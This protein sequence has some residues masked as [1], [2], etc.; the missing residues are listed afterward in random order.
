MSQETDQRRR[1][2]RDYVI[3]QRN[4]LS[5]AQ[6]RSAAH[7]MTLLL[8]STPEFHHAVHIA[9]YWPVKGEMDVLPLIEQARRYNKHVYLPVMVGSTLKFAPYQPDMPMRDNRFGIPEPDVAQAQLVA[10]QDLDLVLVPLV[11]FDDYGNRLGMGGGFYDRTMHFLN[12]NPNAFKPVLVGAAHEF[13]HTG[14]IPAETWDVPTR[15]VATE[16]HVW[17]AT[18]RDP[19]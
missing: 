12:E 15:M 11:V 4:A 5:D 1:E 13:Q 19:A 18:R 2:L 9:A 16:E 8:E 17:R 14:E 7:D 3:E 6:L 10:P